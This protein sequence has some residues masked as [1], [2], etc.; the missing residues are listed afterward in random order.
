MVT[1][2]DCIF[3]RDVSFRWGVKQESDKT[4]ILETE[5]SD[6]SKRNKC[7]NKEVVRRNE[8]SRIPVGK[9]L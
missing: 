3:Q 8:N 4:D 7:W 2:S 9:T 5:H 1:S 6:G